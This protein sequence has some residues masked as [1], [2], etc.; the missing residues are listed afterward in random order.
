MMEESVLSVV[1]KIDS[2]LTTS[3]PDKTTSLDLILEMEFHY[4][5]N[6]IDSALNS[7]LIIL[8]SS[9]WSGSEKTGELS[10]II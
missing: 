1:T 6:T 7:Q 9:L 8:H 2:M 10:I 4:A 5:L 3:S